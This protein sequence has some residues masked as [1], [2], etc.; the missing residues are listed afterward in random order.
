M[1][2]F[3]VSDES[4]DHELEP[5]HDQDWYALA[6]RCGKLCCC[7]K[8]YDDEFTDAADQKD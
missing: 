7:G 1:F 3:T 5:D 6:E 8:E 2:E 4:G